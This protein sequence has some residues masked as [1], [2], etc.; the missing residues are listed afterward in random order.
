MDNKRTGVE[1]DREAFVSHPEHKS[2]SALARLC[3]AV[4]LCLAVGGLGFLVY[5]IMFR[6][7]LDMTPTSG[8][9]LG[10]VQ[11]QLTQIEQRLD[12][13]EQNQRKVAMAPTP[14][15]QKTQKT[16][17]ASSSPVTAHDL[18]RVTYSYIVSPPSAQQLEVQ[19][20][21][22][23]V[24]SGLGVVQ[25]Q[26]VANREAWQ[27]TTDRLADVVGQVGTQ[28]GQILHDQNA[29]NQLLARTERATYSFEVRRDSGRHTVG[30]L[31]IELK[32]TNQRKH[33]YT[34]C[35][36]VQGSCVELKDRSPYEV[37]QFV[38]SRDLTPFELI[39]TKVDKDQVVGY[40]Q[41]PQATT[42][43]SQR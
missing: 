17:P 27:A 5:R 4:F 2:A 38:L 25:N 37:V 30:P 35:I 23:T 19:R 24:Q 10:A 11:M 13:L 36:Y 6:N 16:E 3:L 20:G 15:T 41:V 26:T 7:V 33:Q 43:S 8:Q 18:P 14:S 34:M 28:Q 12:K 1:Y 31:S 29:L 22:G 40:L 32:A 39:A 42:G 21:L 9:A